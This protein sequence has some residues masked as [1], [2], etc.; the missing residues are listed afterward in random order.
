MVG[1]EKPFAFFADPVRVCP[2][3]HCEHA[4]FTSARAGAR[5]PSVHHITPAR[6]DSVFFPIGLK[7]SE[8]RMTKPSGGQSEHKLPSFNF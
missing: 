7:N 5:T 3:W 2:I 4:R 6:P 1:V 8:Y